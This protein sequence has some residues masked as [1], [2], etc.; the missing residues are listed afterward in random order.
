[1][2]DVGTTVRDAFEEHGYEVAG[3]SRNRDRHRVE[4]VDE[5]ADAADLRTIVEDAAGDGV[6][7]IDVSTE[8]P[9]GADGV[10][11]V[12]AFRYRG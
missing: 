5:R 10:R 9:E 12:V 2:S 6:V 7:G 11:T 1:M 8:S 3:V 4:L